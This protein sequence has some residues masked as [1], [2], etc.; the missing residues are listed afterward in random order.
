LNAALMMAIQPGIIESAD[1]RDL[2]DFA[3][4]PIL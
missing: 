3:G 4:N 1:A 2:E